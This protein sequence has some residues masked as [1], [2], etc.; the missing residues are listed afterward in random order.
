MAMTKREQQAKS[1]VMSIL[2]KQGYPTYAEL[3]SLFDMH[4]TK[5]PNV[6]AYMV[7]NKA[8]IVINE[9]LDIEQ[10]STIVRHEILHEYLSHQLRMERHLNGKPG[11]HTQANIAGDYEISNRGYTEQ[12]KRIA[13]SIM[14][15]GKVLSGLVTEDQHP[16]WVDLS[17]EEMYDRLASDMSQEEQEMSSALD[18]QNPDSEIQQAEEAARQAAAAQE[19]AEEAQDQQGSS[20]GSSQGPEEAETGNDELGGSGAEDSDGVDSNASTDGGGTE[21]SDNDNASM[22]PGKAA[23][24][25]S[26]AKKAAQQAAKD[27]KEIEKNAAKKGE[28][29]DTREIRAAK[30]DIQARIEKIKDLLDS[31]AMKD[32]ITGEA[33]SAQ[34]REKERIAQANAARYENS[35]IQRFKYSLNKFIKNELAYTREGTWKKFNKTYA[36]SPIIRKGLASMESQNK[37]SINVYFDHSASWDS[38]KIKVGMDAIGILNNY[39]RR[40]EVLI[41]VYYFGNRVSENPNDTGG[42]TEGTP[43]LEHI[44]QTNPKNV[45]I[46][47]DSDIGDCTYTVKVPGAVWFLFKGG[48]SENIMSA[49]KG[50]K[51]TQAFYL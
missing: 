27:A 12:D 34:I 26:K 33:T 48:I 11:N 4:L 37:P 15:N 29:F 13:R 46:M 49:V 2:G 19:Q 10:V 44:Q 20:G 43:I 21:N 9:W 22:T 14:L 30:E 5:D 1:Q 25:A 23:K 17:F 31:P 28:I 42:G 16:D 6:V 47:T 41:R 38:Q 18:N 50:M 24:Q 36:R 3:L 8:I 45:I 40:G 51:Q 35:P 39:V 7:P 32:A